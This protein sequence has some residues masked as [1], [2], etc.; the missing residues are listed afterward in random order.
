MS[1]GKK[2]HILTYPELERLA[3]LFRTFSEPTRLALLQELKAGPRA[4]GD[5][6]DALHATQ[7]NVSKQ[8][9]HLHQAGLVSRAR[10]GTSVIYSIAEPLVFEICKLACEKLNRDASKL[11]RMRF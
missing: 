2:L 5:L 11:V 1:Q 3:E 7:A 9:K 8:L 4:V 6:V 10:D